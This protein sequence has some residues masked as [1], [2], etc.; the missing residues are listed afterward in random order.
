MSEPVVNGG[1][2][3]RAARLS[4]G[5]RGASALWPVRAAYSTHEPSTSSR[6]PPQQLIEPPP[7]RR[8][9][10]SYYTAWY[11]RAVRQM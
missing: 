3:A 5:A 1:S 2:G 8:L 10:P 6:G 9:A 7:A 11:S 4:A